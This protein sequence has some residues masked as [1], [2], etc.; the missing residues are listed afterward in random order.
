M[1]GLGL[2]LGLASVGCLARFEVGDASGDAQSSDTTADGAS[3]TAEAGTDGAGTGG[4]CA[5]NELDCSGTCV[6]PQTDPANC[7]GCGEVCS[8]GESCELGVCV[9]ACAPA[10][11]PIVEQC[12]GGECA[13]RDEFTGCG[14]ECVDLDSDPQNCGGCSASCDAEVCLAGECQP[15]CQEAVDC[16]GACVE[17]DQSPLHCGSCDN[18]CAS[19]ELCVEGACYGFDP[20]DCNTDSDCTVGVCCE[21][22]EDKVC[23]HGAQCP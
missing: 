5:A 12:V 21:L 23:L 16:D 15:D 17:L 22:D 8:A 2:I 20:V 4:D 6:S 14:G 10:C 19:D 13:C 7:G 1:I 18:A 11:D 3:A 9:D